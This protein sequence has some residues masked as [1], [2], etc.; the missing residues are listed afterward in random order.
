MDMSIIQIGISKRCFGIPLMFDQRP[1]ITGENLTTFLFD[2]IRKI[3]KWLAI[4]KIM[5]KYML[6]FVNSTYKFLEKFGQFAENLNES[7]NGPNGYF[8]KRLKLGSCYDKGIEKKV[9]EQATTK[10]KRN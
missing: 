4:R 10:N 5:S 9:Q 6:S 2:S 7:V 3:Y 8:A 1:F